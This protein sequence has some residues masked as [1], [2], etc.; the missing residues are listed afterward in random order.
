MTASNQSAVNLGFAVARTALYSVN[1]DVN[2]TIIL[3]T[4]NN[5]TNY[6]KISN[7]SIVTELQSY[8]ENSGVYKLMVVIGIILCGS[9]KLT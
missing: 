9:F 2:I 3:I 8:N 6:S 4:I 1:C 7:L 5:S